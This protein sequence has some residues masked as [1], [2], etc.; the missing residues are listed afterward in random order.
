ME[1]LCRIGN[2]WRHTPK[3]HL[4][5]LFPSVGD[6]NGCVHVRN[7][8][9]QVILRQ[10]VNAGFGVHQIIRQCRRFYNAGVALL[11]QRLQFLHNAIPVGRILLVFSNFAGKGLG[12]CYNDG[13]T[14][15]EEAEQPFH[16]NDF[17]WILTIAPRR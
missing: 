3:G 4:F 8:T 14:A 9:G 6:S 2:P 10:A 5:F 17:T 16:I 15:K 13:S 12:V 11:F 1:W 7:Q